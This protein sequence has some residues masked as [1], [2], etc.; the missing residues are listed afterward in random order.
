MLK[1]IVVTCAVTGAGDTT[2]KSKYVPI[3]PKEIAESAIKAAKEGATIAHIHVRDPD[4]GGIS[5]DLEHYREVV[6][7][8]REQD[9]DV[10]INITAGG[11]GDWVPSEEDPAVG[12]P[13][14]WMQ[15][16]RERHAPVEKLLPEMCTLDC[17]SLNFGNQVYINTEDWLREHA[18]LIQQSGVKPELEIFDTGQFRLAMQLIEEGLIDGDPLFQFCM[19]IPW[20]MNADAETLLY[21]RNQLPENAHWSAF[22]IGRHQIPMAV[23]TMLLGGHVRVGLEDNLYLERGVLATNE[24][25]VHKVVSIMQSLGSEPMRPEEARELLQLKK[26]R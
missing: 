21:M 23:Q 3:T 5:H 1:K 20:G 12:G 13:G 22:G 17:G 15:T 11:G 8:I 24:Q 4:T 7:R 16:P 6:E 9:T 2:K 19:G 10:I 18:K 26:Q 14:T 25:L